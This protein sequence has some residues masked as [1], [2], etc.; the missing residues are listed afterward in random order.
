MT[1]QELLSVTLRLGEEYVL[2]YLATLLVALV[3][4]SFAMWA[5][6]RRNA[7]LAKGLLRA[8][9]RT[10]IEVSKSILAYS[11]A[12]LTSEATVQPMPR[13]RDTAYLE[14]KRAGLLDR[15]PRD[16]AEQLVDVYLYIE[17]VNEAGRR[18]EDLAF[19]P[20]A[21]WPNSHELRIQNLTYIQD[22]IHNVLGP[23]Q[24]RLP[25]MKI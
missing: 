14:Y 10:N 6:A 17:S 15:L 13:Y 24:G 21:A 12:Q 4:V 8:E 18:Q 25:K 23:Y 3:T 1:P 2:P 5:S 19:G 9:I 11:Q 22:T 7:G 16:S 20:S